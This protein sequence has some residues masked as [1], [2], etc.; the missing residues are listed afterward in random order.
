VGGGDPLKILQIS[1]QDLGG[2][3]EKIAWKIH[4]E[5]VDRGHES[6]LLVGKKLSSD[7]TVVELPTAIRYRG[8]GYAKIVVDHLLGYQYEHYPASHHIPDLVGS[9]WDVI[10]THNLHGSYFDVSALSRLQSLAPVILTLHDMWL[11]TG[12]CAHPLGSDGWLRGCG[13]CCELSLY[14]QIRRDAARHNLARKKRILDG[15]RYWVV[16]TARWLEEVVKETYLSV[17]PRRRISNPVDPQYFKPGDREGVRERMGIRQDRH[18][19][20]LP[21]NLDANNPYKGRKIF[22]EAV[23]EL[24]DLDLLSL[25]FEGNEPAPKEVRVLPRTHDEAE[26]AGYYHAADVT[27]LSSLADT[28]PL[29]VLESFACGVPV[30]GTDVGGIREMVKDRQTGRLV[31]PGDHRGLARAIRTVIEAPVESAVLA[32]NAVEQVVPR[33]L[34]GHIVDQWVDLYE[35]VV[36]RFP[37][38]KA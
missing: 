17:H 23:A 13:S 30:V 10:Q 8:L 19:V 16:P 5:L 3:A 36:S 33:H 1:T 25:A 6:L 15:G 26:V 11:L 2:G 18:V 9:N 37:K 22:L 4:R 21:A 35:E 14:P 20:L 28:Y 34:L 32:K 29:T 12:H 31:Q 27:V 38:R 24:R 7:P